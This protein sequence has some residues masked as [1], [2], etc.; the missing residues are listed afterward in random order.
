[1]FVCVYASGTYSCFA[2]KRSAAIDRLSAALVSSMA[3]YERRGGSLAAGPARPMRTGVSFGLLARCRPAGSRNYH[4]RRRPR[5]RTRE[6]NRRKQT[7]TPPPPPTTT[8]GGPAAPRNWSRC[9]RRPQLIPWARVVVSREPPATK[10]TE[11]QTIDSR[12][13]LKF[14]STTTAASTTCG[15]PFFSVCRARE[16]NCRATPSPRG[17]L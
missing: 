11:S 9:R 3:N 17:P 4:S 5:R 10:Q 15:P 2:C 6:T 14:E 7:R 13:T 12:A 8:E 1:V 16:R